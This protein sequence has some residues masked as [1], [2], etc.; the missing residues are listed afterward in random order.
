MH[1][2]LFHPLTSELIFGVSAAGLSQLLAA[3]AL[4]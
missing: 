2:P 1:M 4:M 3:S